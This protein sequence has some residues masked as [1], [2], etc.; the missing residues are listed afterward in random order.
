MSAEEFSRMTRVTT[1]VFVVVLVSFC[2]V[3]LQSRTARALPSGVWSDPVQISSTELYF[4]DVDGDVVYEY[5]WSNMA[6]SDDSGATWNPELSFGGKLDASD[7]TLYRVDGVDVPTPGT[8]AFL[9]STDE[10]ATWSSPIPIMQT[11]GNDGGY[12]IAKFSSTIIVY[13]FDYAGTSYGL[14]KSSK[15]TDDGATWSLPVIVDPYVHCEDP[16]ASPMVYVDGKVYLTY[17][18]Y[19]GYGPSF[20]DIVVINSPDMG[21]T[22][23]G[24]TVVGS[25]YSPM[26]AAVPGSIYVTFWDGGGLCFTKSLDGYIWTSPIV[27]GD[28]IKI[29][30]PQVLHS[31]C[32]AGETVFVA[33]ITYDNPGGIDEFWV[34]VS[35]SGDGG[36]TWE[37]MG[38]VTGGDGDEMYPSVMFDGAMLHLT[39]VDA[40]GEGGWGGVTF[41]RSLTLNEPVPEFGTVLIPLT[42]TALLV[43]GLLFARR[44]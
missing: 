29:T 42:C 33:Y 1:A 17:Y 5:G 28:F 20:S 15:S 44:R 8:L 34:H 31:V 30:D 18:N 21:S 32:A 14:I 40:Q 11:D 2:A 35:Y 6:V 39:W 7:G 22:W 19:S 12:R 43:A 26:I 36:S 24:R 25:G 10:G 41:Y 13:S 4:G 37:D 38:N 16:L 3:L 9:K 27:V 23:E